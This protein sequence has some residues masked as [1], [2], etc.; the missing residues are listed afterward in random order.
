MTE[1]VT[2]QLPA[3]VLKTYREWAQQQER[4]VEETLVCILCSLAVDVKKDIRER[5]RAYERG[6]LFKTPGGTP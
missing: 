5:K 6:E 3:S 4:S 2:I 1:P